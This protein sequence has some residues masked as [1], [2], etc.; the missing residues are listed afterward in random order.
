MQ[1]ILIDRNFEF[2]PRNFGNYVKATIGVICD[3]ESQLLLLLQHLKQ[4]DLGDKY[5][6]TKTL[7][8]PVAEVKKQHEEAEIKKILDKYQN[9]GSIGSLE[10]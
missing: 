2:Q 4:L 7:T 6:Q 5:K 3:N 9:Q 8:D 1:A 10:L